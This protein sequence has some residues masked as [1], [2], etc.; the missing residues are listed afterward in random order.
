[1]V[2]ECTVNNTN[3]ESSTYISGN[4]VGMSNK[5]VIITNIVCARVMWL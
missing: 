1:M 3:Y 5:I 4:N 2:V